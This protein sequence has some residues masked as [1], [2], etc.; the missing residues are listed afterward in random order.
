L[1]VVVKPRREANNR[2]IEILESV[3]ELNAW[4]RTHAGKKGWHTEAFV[5]G[6]LCHANALVMNGAVVP[7]QVGMYTSPL[8]ALNTGRPAGSFTL[9]DASPVAIAGRRLNTDVIKVLGADGAFVVHTE[10]FITPHGDPI[11]L[12]AAARAPG[13]LVS[14]IAVLH[15]GI[16]LEEANFSLQIGEMV[17]TPAQTG[18]YAG[19]LWFPD[20]RILA[21]EKAGP[22]PLSSDYR[23]QRQ[24]SP[25]PAA[26]LAW[27]RDFDQLLLDLTQAELV[28]GSSS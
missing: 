11:L 18:V 13:A 27:N 8:L 5:T 7:I 6:K 23:L 28:G 22:L 9:P 2:G 20:P 16:H 10:F 15:A 24:V 19:W 14:E 21:R 25:V 1:P 26:L 12:E 4:L 17:A 3:E